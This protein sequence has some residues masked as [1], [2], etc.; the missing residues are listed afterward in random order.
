LSEPRRFEPPASPVSEP[1]WEATRRR[2]LVLQWC[3]DCNEPIFYPREACPRC[4]GSQL[5]WRPSIGH[6]EVYA[7]S[8]Q[9]RPAMPMPAFTQGPYAVVLVELAEGIRMMSNVIGCPAN[10]ITVGMPVKVTW[11]P[12][13]DGRNLPQFE[14]AR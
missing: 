3:V 9:H 7:V 11:E 4:F 13:S 2:E 6:G 14:P 10:Q 8:V 5:E 1:F 12:L